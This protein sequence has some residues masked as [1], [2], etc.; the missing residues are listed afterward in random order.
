MKRPPP[1][2]R[3]RRVSYL[4]HDYPFIPPCVTRRSEARLYALVRRLGL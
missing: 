3:N 2:Y 4:H 1:R